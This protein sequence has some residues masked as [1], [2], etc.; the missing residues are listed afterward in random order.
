MRIDIRWRKLVRDLS[1]YRG[2]ALALVVAVS[3]SVVSLSTMLG[4]LGIVTREIAANYLKTR[5][6]HISIELDEVTPQVLAAARNFPG[7]AMAEARAVIEARAKVGHEWMRMLLFVVEDFGEMR[8]NAF[9]HESGAWPPPAGSMLIERQALDFLKARDGGSIEVRMP[10]GSTHSVPI[11]GI[12][13]DTTVAPS[14]QEQTGYGYLARSSL[15]TLAV[16]PVL[17]ELR[18]LLDGNPQDTKVIDAK[19][20]EIA[21]ALRAQG[22]RVRSIKVPPPGKHPHE[23]LMQAGLRNFALLSALALVLSAILVAAVLAAILARQVREIGI[24]KAVGARSGQ[25]AGMYGA[26]LL[27]LGGISIAIGL[28][29]GLVLANGR[30]QAIADTMNF[31][32]TGSLV[33]AWVYAMVVGCSLLVPLL[34]S[35]PIV[36]GASRKTV[37]EALGSF[38]VPS[39]FGTQRLDRALTSL[40]GPST[41]TSLPCATPSAAAGASGWRSPCLRRAAGSS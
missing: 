21:N 30:A 23:E 25:I 35:L 18:I 10:G 29:L 38:G 19:A 22:A 34:V 41:P 26:L 2:R 9:S 36:V 31:T 14:W 39:S 40:G 20:V 28:P 6:A 37:R 13:H 3:A 33:P 11:S 1:G 24:M 5:P 27:V 15:A 7:I 16:P 17:D 12:V 32:V 8:L 4:A